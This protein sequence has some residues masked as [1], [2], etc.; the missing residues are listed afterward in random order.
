MDSLYS[1]KMAAWP[2]YTTH[3]K[4]GSVF[5]AGG[6]GRTDRGWGMD[7]HTLG[8]GADMG[9]VVPKPAW[10]GILA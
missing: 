5:V 2:T 7:L 10:V 4:V 9:A 3:P 8:I 1:W 6:K